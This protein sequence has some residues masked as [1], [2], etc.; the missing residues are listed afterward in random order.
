MKKKWTHDETDEV[1][2]T[3]YARLFLDSMWL[4]IKAYG[5]ELNIHPYNNICPIHLSYVYRKNG[6]IEIHNLLTFNTKK[7]CLWAP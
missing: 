2:W 4:I 7:T 6:I 3:T 1:N 5:Y